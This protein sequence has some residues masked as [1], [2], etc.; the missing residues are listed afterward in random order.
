MS[1]KKIIIGLIGET[2]SGKDTVSDYIKKN[3]PEVLVLRFSD[4]LREALGIF[5]NEKRKE[6][7]Q[8]L[9]IVLRE[10]FGGD[11]LWQALKKKIENVESGIVILNGIRFADEYRGIKQ[12][13]GKIIYV[14]VDSKIRWQRVRSRGEKKDDRVSYKKFLQIERAATELQIPKLGQKADFIIKNDGSIE[15]F[16]ARIKKVLKMI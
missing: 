2:G 7:Q 3:Y 11:I 9:A 4:P 13:G 10:R 15:D 12:I 16:Y 8:W 5:L 1:K 14:T 6:D